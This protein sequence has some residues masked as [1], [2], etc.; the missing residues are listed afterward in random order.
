MNA[1]LLV[2]VITGGLL[3]SGCYRRESKATMA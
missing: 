1:F 2:L 3:A